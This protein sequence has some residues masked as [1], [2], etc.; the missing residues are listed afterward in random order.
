LTVH[1][2]TQKSLLL[3]AAG[4]SSRMGFP[5][6]ALLHKDKSHFITHILVQYQ[7]FG[8][9]DIVVVVN[10]ESAQWIQDNIP[11]IKNECKII[12]N[13]REESERFYSIQVGLQNRTNT[14]SS[15]FIHNVDN[16]FVDVEILHLLW[17]NK[18]QAAIIKPT[19]QGKGGHPVLIDR[20][21][22]EQIILEKDKTRILSDFIKQ[23]SIKSVP[24]NNSGI[25]LN[26]NTPEAYKAFV[27]SKL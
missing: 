8:I 6:L 16:P 26:I 23:F 22:S 10:R 18:N 2:F 14:N 17:K 4:K 13:T 15:V 7:S 19:F 1:N 20:Q 24:V 5:K 12:L 27:R 11:H 21:V 9:S 25:L 3:L